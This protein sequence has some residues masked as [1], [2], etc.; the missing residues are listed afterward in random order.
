MDTL[1]PALESLLDDAKRALEECGVE[2]GLVTLAPGS[3]VAWDNCCE[4][5]GELWVRVL[6][7]IPQ[8]QGSQPCDITDLKVRIGMGVV[9]CMH[10]LNDEGFPTAEQMTGDTLAMTQDADILLRAIRNWE[11]PTEVNMK[12]LVVESGTSLGPSG[13]CGGWEWTLGFRYQTCAGC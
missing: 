11:G 4:G 12:S 10:G 1:G 8:P 5:G 2:P 3:E 7:I 6:N 13:F 9:R